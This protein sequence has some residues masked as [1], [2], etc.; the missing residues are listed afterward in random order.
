MVLTNEIKKNELIADSSGLFKILEDCMEKNKLLN[1]E[2]IIL[3]QEKQKHINIKND[4]IKENENIKSELK[5]I[6]DWKNDHICPKE[7]IEN[8]KEYIIMKEEI[9]NLNI[10]NEKLKQQYKTYED[11]KKKH[12]KLINILNLYNIGD[13]DLINIINNNKNQKKD[14]ILD[15]IKSNYVNYKIN[16]EIVDNN[17]D[18]TIHLIDDNY[19]IIYLNKSKLIYN[20]YVIYIKYLDI[21]KKNKKMEFDYF[22]KHNYKNN[23]LPL[24]KIK[25]SYEFFNDLLIVIKDIPSYFKYTKINILIEILKRC[26]LSVNILFKLENNEYEDLIDFLKPLIMEECKLKY[27]K[28]KEMFDNN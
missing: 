6:N 24:D 19:N 25:R 20:Y 8:T 11:E 12:D 18:D 7:K 2:L 17:I 14:N 9:N 1:N 4:V 26:K 22:I 23:C 21:K 5:K 3:N 27:E 28:D 16:I 10:N 15:I 13:T